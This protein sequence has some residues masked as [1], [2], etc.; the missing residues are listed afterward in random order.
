MRHPVASIILS[1]QPITI[2]RVRA[3]YFWKITKLLS[4]TFEAVEKWLRLIIERFVHLF[5]VFKANYFFKLK[6]LHMFKTIET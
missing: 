4:I 3:L 5:M 2:R 6:L 1:I